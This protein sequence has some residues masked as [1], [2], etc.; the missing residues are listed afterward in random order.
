MRLQ[1]FLSADELRQLEQLIYANVYKA[2]ATYQQQQRLAVI[3]RQQDSTSTVKPQATKRKKQLA[4]KV[5]RTPHVAAPKPLP[6]PKPQV[7]PQP[8]A[9]KS[10]NP[11]KVP[12]PLPAPT[13]AAIKQPPVNQGENVRAIGNVDQRGRA[14]LPKHHR[15]TPIWDLVNKQ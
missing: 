5:K 14:M 15:D 1:E 3:Q 12:K 6:Q 8:S 13:R 2:L 9:P 4:S 11:I 7:T 10:Y